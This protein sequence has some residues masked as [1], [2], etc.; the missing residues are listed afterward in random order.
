MLEGVALGEGALRRGRRA[1]FA[2]APTLASSLGARA[3][4]PPLSPVQQERAGR[5]RSQEGGKGEGMLR[6][7][8]AAPIVRGASALKDT[9]NGAHPPPILEFRSGRPI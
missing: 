6:L 1:V 3:S 4:R 9:A 5:P 8:E 7:A 2:S